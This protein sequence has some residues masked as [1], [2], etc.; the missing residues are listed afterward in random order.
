MKVLP[1]IKPYTLLISPFVLLVLP[2]Q[3]RKY[4]QCVECSK[5]FYKIIIETSIIYD[6]TILC[7]TFCLPFS[8]PCDMMIKA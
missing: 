8:L 2:K 5:R 4:Y 1:F 7:I 6:E 3:Y